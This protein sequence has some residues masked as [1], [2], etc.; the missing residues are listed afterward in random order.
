MNHVMLDLETLGSGPNAA[1]IAIGAVRFDPDLQCIGETFY[2]V[3]DLE[4]ATQAGGQIDASTALWWLKQTDAARAA[5]SQPGVPIAEALNDFAGWL[6]ASKDGPLI[7]G[8]G[9]AFDNVILA[10]AYKRLHNKN[11]WP[12]WNDRCYR[13]LKNLR[14]EIKLERIGTDHHALDDAMNQAR[15]AITILNAI[16][17]ELA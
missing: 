2:R 9:A 5:I 16:K 11:P 12:H 17:K 10:S 3:I 7:W 6:N 1:I 15:H 8:N 13:T 4:S 14:P